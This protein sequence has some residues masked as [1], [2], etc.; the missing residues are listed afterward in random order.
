MW[1][2]LEGN[3]STKS[4]HIWCSVLSACWYI[5]PYTL[6]PILSAP[7]CSWTLMVECMAL[8]GIYFCRW[9]QSAPRC[10][11]HRYT[12][13]WVGFEIEQYRC[14]WKPGKSQPWRLYLATLGGYFL[15]LCS[16]AV[17]T[18]SP[19]AGCLAFTFYS[20]P[21]CRMH[22]ASKTSPHTAAESIWHYRSYSIAASSQTSPKNLQPLPASAG[23]NLKAVLNCS[24]HR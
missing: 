13:L 3:S 4:G 20:P 2:H 23:V 21:E 9:N 24:A 6:C 12:R 16:C 15:P 18:P 1:K 8:L 17:P 10:T 7:R 5:I 14:R 11:S 22:I 19:V